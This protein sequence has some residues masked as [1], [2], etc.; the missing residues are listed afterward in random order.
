MPLVVVL[1]DVMLHQQPLFSSIVF[2]IFLCSFFCGFSLLTC[3][4]ISSDCGCTIGN[5]ISLNESSRLFE[6][7]RRR[8]T[9]ESSSVTLTKVFCGLFVWYAGS[10]EKERVKVHIVINEQKTFWSRVWLGFVDGKQLRMTFLF[11]LNFNFC[12]C[13]SELKILP[14]FGTRTKTKNFCSV[15]LMLVN[16]FLLFFGFSLNLFCFHSFFLRDSP[17]QTF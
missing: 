11:T 7:R 2:N 13:W 8:N 1:H 16:P 10:K 9:W 14:H 15:F 12:T 6:R 4:I 17:A 5:E 3:F